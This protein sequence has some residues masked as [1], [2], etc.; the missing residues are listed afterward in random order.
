MRAPSAL[1]AVLLALVLAVAGCV[2]PAWDDHDYALKGEQ[3]AKTALSKVEI[4]R[5]AVADSRRLPQPYLETLLTKASSDLS[6]VETQFGGVQPPTRR[7]D[8]LRDHLLDLVQQAQAEVQGLLI[9]VRRNGIED[10]AGSANRLE[11]IAEELR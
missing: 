2:S 9:Q 4:V 7:S 8:R 3:T 1:A 6:N 5:I 10:P 11:R